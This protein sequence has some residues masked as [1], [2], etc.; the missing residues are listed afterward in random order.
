MEEITLKKNALKAEIEA[1]EELESKT[2]LEQQKIKNYE[3][4]KKRES[5]FL[6]GKAYCTPN[7]TWYRDTSEGLTELGIRISIPG[8]MGSTYKVSSGVPSAVVTFFHNVLTDEVR[9]ELQRDL[10][11][12]VERLIEKTLS[13]PKVMIEMLGLQSDDYFLRR[14]DHYPKE[15]IETMEQEIQ[16]ERNNVLDRFTE[17]EL[18]AIKR[19]SHGRAILI[20]YAESRGLTKLLK[21]L[22]K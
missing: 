16:Q 1:L 8:N 6:L 13:N 7:E 10:N 17:E 5:V 9:R 21:K 11:S 19:P 14:T 12:V 2:A 15:C 18:L 22:N 20:N 4:W 3:A